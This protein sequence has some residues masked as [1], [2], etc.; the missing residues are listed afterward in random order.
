[1]NNGYGAHPYA[2]IPYAGWVIIGLE[3]EFGVAETVNAPSTLHA[4]KMLLS[5]A[6]SIETLNNLQLSKLAVALAE[7]VDTVKPLVATNH[8]TLGL[9]V[10]IDQPFYMDDGIVRI[11]FGL[12]VDEETMIPPATTKTVAA[13]AETVEQTDAQFAVLLELGLAE[14]V[15]QTF[16]TELLKHL[17]LDPTETIEQTGLGTTKNVVTG[18]TVTVEETGLADLVKHLGLDLAQMV[19]QTNPI[20]LDKATEFFSAGII[21]YAAGRLTK[22][23]LGRLPLQI[24]VPPTL[25]NGYSIHPT[26]PLPTTVQPV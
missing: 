9:A 20:N 13:A 15:D 26:T 12:A 2:G 4:T 21:E 7:T 18:P 5:Q 16:R 25:T 10:V 14:T 11:F 22:I 19:D 17:N 24:R 23:I 8:K 1:M 3:H 6:T